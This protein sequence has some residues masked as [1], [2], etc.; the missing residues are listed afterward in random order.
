MKICVC[1]KHVPDP[2][3]PVQVDPATRRLIR[4]PKQSILDPADEYGVET[5]LRLVEEHGGEVV[6][7]TMGPPAAED[8]LRRAMAMGADRA[9]LVSDE[10]LAGSDVLGT[11]RALAAAI[12]PEQPDL[13]I[14][15]TESTDAYTGLLP[16]A[17]AGLLDLPQL[18]FARAV[19]VEG[20]TVTVQRATET[21][22]QVIQATLPALV[23]V[24]ASVGEP[25]YPSF[26]GLMAAK[27]KPIEVRDIAEL[28]LEQHTVGEPGARERVLEISA[29]RQVKQGRIVV[30]DGTGE[31][32]EEILAFLRSIQVV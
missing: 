29:V 6:A 5:A 11:A 28:G 26:K 7:V 18:T 17:L 16:G 32:V 22:Y 10:A 8:A 19:S 21:G 12:R 20:S 3:L 24:T 23:T 13:V 1:V 4:D 31:S 30:D 14:C 25:R 2:N 27:R 9:I 15:A